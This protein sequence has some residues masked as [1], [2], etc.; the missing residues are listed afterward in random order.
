[1]E[2]DYTIKRSRIRKHGIS[3]TNVA[4]AQGNKIQQRSVKSNEHINEKR[5]G[6]SRG[7]GYLNL[8]S[9][10]LNLAKWSQSEIL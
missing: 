7:S 5:D 8:F 1:M 4:E 3:C 9:D 2:A 10:L 6:P